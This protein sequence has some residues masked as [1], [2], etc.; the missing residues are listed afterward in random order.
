MTAGIKLKI[1]D[2]EGALRKTHGNFQLSANMLKCSREAIRKRVQASE[3]LMAIAKEEREG[4]IDVAES[5]LQRAVLEGEAWAVQF[6][7]RNLGRDRGYFEKQQQE[8]TGKDGGPIKEEITLNVAEE[9]KKVAHLLPDV[10]Q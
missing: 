2:I 3:Q 8:I 6:T 1:K 7:L 10:K 5:A 9:V 4:V